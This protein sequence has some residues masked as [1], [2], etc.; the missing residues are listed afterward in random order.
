MTAQSGKNRFCAICQIVTERSKHSMTRIAISIV[1]NVPQSVRMQPRLLRNDSQ[2]SVL[3]LLADQFK[4]K[5][6]CE[7]CCVGVL[8]SYA[9]LTYSVNTA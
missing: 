2:S 4:C 5:H 6:D 7:K 8:T 9:R 1:A 3:K